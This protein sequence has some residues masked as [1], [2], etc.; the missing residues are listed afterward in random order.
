MPHC[1][2]WN[3]TDWQLEVDTAQIHGA[4]GAIGQAV[5]R[6]P[7][8]QG[9]FRRSSRVPQP[10]TRRGALASS[11]SALAR[12]TASTRFI[13]SPGIA[14]HRASAGTKNSCSSGSRSA[15]SRAAPAVA[16]SST[17]Q[18]PMVVEGRQSS[19]RRR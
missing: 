2:L 6:R 13:D 15:T 9:S 8:F 14:G 17:S 10:A 11:I 19:R 7:D 18:G 16:T 5:E 1:F 3:A 4:Y 12:F